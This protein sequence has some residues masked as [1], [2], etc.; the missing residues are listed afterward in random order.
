MTNFPYVGSKTEADD[1]ENE[2]EDANADGDAT[3][4]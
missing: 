3:Q 2:D 4:E 1:K